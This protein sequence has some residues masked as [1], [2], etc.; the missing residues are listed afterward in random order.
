MKEIVSLC[1][2]WT[3]STIPLYASESNPKDSL[4]TTGDSIHQTIALKEIVITPEMVKHFDNRTSY[5]ISRK[6]LKNYVTFDKALNTL[7]FINVTT[8]GDISYKGQNN[9]IVLLNGVK[10][11]FQEIQSLKKEDVSKV[12]VYD[13]PPAQY[14]LEN[15]TAVINIITKNNLTGGNITLNLIDSFHPAYGTNT[16]GSNYN[17]KN[18][19]FSILFDNSISHYKKVQTDESLSYD[20]NGNNYA[21]TK[22]GIN[23]PWNTD[24]NNLTL[25]YMYNKADKI[26]FNANLSTTF[27]KYNKDNSQYINYSDG[28]TANGINNLNNQYKKYALNLYLYKTW[29][30]GRNLLIDITGTL[31]HTTYHSLYNELYTNGNT[32]LESLSDYTTHRGSILSTIQYARS[33]SWGTLSYGIKDSYQDGIQKDVDNNLH[34]IQNTLYGFAQLYGHKN[35]FNYQITAAAKYLYI[36]KDNNKIWSKIYPSPKV[37]IWYNPTKSI[38]LNLGYSYTSEVPAVS[39]MSETEQWLDGHYIYKGNTELHP[40]Q[41]HQVMAYVSSVSKH[42]D[43]SFVGLFNYMPNDIINYFK[44]TSQYIMQSYA[45]LKFKTELGGQLIVN[46]YPLSEKTL[47]IGAIGIYMHHHGVEKEGSSWNG[48]R[49]QFMAY[50]NYANS[51]WECELFYQ[52]PGQTMTGQ[53]VTPRAKVLRL[54][55]A[56]KP[57]S[58][59]SIGIQWNQPFMKGLKEGEHTT[60]S[61]MIHSNI[62]YLIKDWS[63]M[64]CLKF[65]YNIPFG[66]KRTSATQKIK[67]EDNDSG[68]LMK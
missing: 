47:K 51:K 12:D 49:Y 5:R 13:N 46:Y 19:H 14:A 65:A 60:S 59:M 53:L 39:L 27:Y 7:P 42:L 8:S 68:I 41:Q 64:I 25:G 6:I 21:K 18:S 43:A 55:I 66:K 24:N 10:T 17:Y 36:G 23:S 57:I 34:Q 40:Y 67:N 62:E 33:Y 35:N 52:Y 9:I 30:G 38:T 56:Y 63:N 29:K 2:C 61:A 20:W 11:T 44:S 3:I 32:L 50:I 16:I 45:N 4:S 58:N 54:D 48:Y 26:Q 31:Y 37:N 22:S 1:F 15:A 28:T